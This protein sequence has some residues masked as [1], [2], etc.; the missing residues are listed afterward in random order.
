[1]TFNL[2]FV[3]ACAFGITY[4]KLLL[5]LV[6]ISIWLLSN[7]QMMYHSST[8]LEQFVFQ[9][10]AVKGSHFCTPLPNLDNVRLLIILPACWLKLCSS[11]YFNL[12]FSIYLAFLPVF[13]Y[14]SLWMSVHVLCHCFCIFSFSFSFLKTFFTCN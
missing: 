12:S 3:V 5:N 10:T 9:L 11:Y 8:W 7:L 6:N 14:S 13:P 1:M 4:K 2:F